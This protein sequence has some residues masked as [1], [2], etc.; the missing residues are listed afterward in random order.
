MRLT[1]PGSFAIVAIAAGSAGAADLR[2]VPKAPP[3]VA[4]P[5]YSWTGFY[6]G[7]N[8]GYSVAADPSTYALGNVGATPFDLESFKIAPA[9][10]LA[11]VQAGYNWQ[12]SNWVL[13]LEADFQGTGQKDSVCVNLCVFGPGGN[14]AGTVDAKVPWFGTVR[15]RL[16]V[17]AG[18]TLFYATGGLAYGRVDTTISETNTFP[19]FVPGTVTVNTSTNKTSWALGGG[20]EAALAGGWTGKVEY[21]YIDLG[22]QTVTFADSTP[23]RVDTFTTSTRD[24]I[25]RAGVNYRFGG[26]PDVVASGMPMPVKAPRMAAAPL[27]N[28]TGV[29][30]GVNAGYSVGSNP[31]T[32]T[33][34]DP[35]PVGTFN[36]ESYKVSPQGVLGGGQVGVNWQTASW[37]IGIEADLQ[38]TAQSDS[39]CVFE[40]S[41]NLAVFGFTSTVQQ[42]LPWFGTVR[43][44]LGAAAGPALFYATGGLAYGKAETNIAQDLGSPVPD[45][46]IL[47]V[48]QTNTG[49]TFGGGLEAASLGIGR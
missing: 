37:V 14:F 5:A 18:R 47:N 9:G 42:K 12:V 40:C 35:P 16:G 26:A 24:H 29:Y 38:A 48:S 33:V 32:Y 34:T 21:L 1:V 36:A 43:G 31:N 44:R 20:I 15:G 45:T 46:V 8:A 30:V 25:V 27:Y 10:A 4:A 7:G 22:S 19:G 28:W 6:I 39:A 3:L 13:G 49:W 17:A 41:T 23:G 11:G 2:V